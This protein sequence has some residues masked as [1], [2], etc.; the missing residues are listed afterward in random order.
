MPNLDDTYQKLSA[1]PTPLSATTTNPPS[2]L[3]PE[4]TIDFDIEK[5]DNESATIAQR[6]SKRAIVLSDLE[7]SGVDDE[8]RPS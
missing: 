7:E 8:S 4:L 1:A 2:S 6:A 3:T 5:S